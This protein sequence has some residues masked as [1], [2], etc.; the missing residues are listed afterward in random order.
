MGRAVKRALLFSSLALAL[1]ACPAPPPGFPR[2]TSVDPSSGEANVPI[3]TTIRAQLEIPDADGMVNITTLTEAT[4]SLIPTGGT[5]VEASRTVSEDGTLSVD[6]VADLA[7]NTVYQFIVT[8]GLETET[9][10]A[11][12]LFGSEFTTGTG[13]GIDNPDLTRG[14]IPDR[15]RVVFSAGGDS[16]RDTRTLTL[17]NTG[18]AAIDVSGLSISG[19]DAR[20]FRLADD[21]A[22]SLAPNE[23]RALEL[24]FVPG[25]L[26]PQFAALT[27]TSND[28][29]SPRLEIPLGGLGVRGQ[30]GN[31]EPSLQWI[32]DTYGLDINAGDDDPSSTGLVGEATNSVVGDEVRVQRFRKADGVSEV[33]V[34]VLAAFGVE[35]N[36]VVEFGTYTAGSMDTRE[37]LF[38]IQQTPTLNGQRLAPTVEPTVGD[39][40]LNSRLAFD[41]GTEAFGVYSFWPGNRFF[42]QRHVY[43]EDVLNTFENAIPH[44]VRAYPLKAADGTPEPNTYVLATEE[45][46]QGFDYNDVVVILRGVVPVAGGGPRDSITGIPDLQIR[47]TLGLPYSDRMLLHHIGNTSGNLCND[48]PP[49]DPPEDPPEEDQPPEEPPEDPDPPCNPDARPWVN[50]HLR[51]T[52][53]VELRNLGSTALQLSLSVADSNL[54]VI[55]SSALTLQPGESYPLTVQF[56]PR[57]LPGKGIYESRLNVTSG[58]YSA[59]LELVGLYQGR[60]EGGREVYL[61]GVINDAFGYPIDLGTNRF[62]GISNSAAGSALVGDEVRSPYWEAANPSSPVTGTQIAAFHACCNDSDIIGLYARGGSRYYGGTRH[63]AVDSQTLFPRL[64]GRPNS[65]TTFSVATRGPFDIRIEQ[66]STNPRIGAGN[67]ENGP[68]LGVRLWPL[69]DRTGDVVENTYLVVQDFV[70]AGCGSEDLANCD[71]NDNIYIVTNITPAN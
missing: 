56:R 29:Q 36:P 38:E 31:L 53:E 52:G 17:Y 42:G 10:T 66:Y 26:G 60:P 43:S 54:F 28:A 40:D 13:K 71:Y 1:C 57:G 65:L 69:R 51:N 68:Q 16:S 44:Q 15:E 49:E 5:P 24:T 61:K 19:E 32:F 62:G 14:L 27:V 22:F 70:R 46:T 2:V 11:F 7:P 18:N 39:L 34:E 64:R 25:G 55:P 23:S 58:S 41:P 30:G 3:N 47:N 33:S 4:V 9:G 48:Q 45:F 21:S 59:S 37:P 20:R 35:N 6:P 12:Q 50:L 8:P 67:G 63:E